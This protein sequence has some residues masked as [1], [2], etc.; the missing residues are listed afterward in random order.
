MNSR[1]LAEEAQFYSKIGS[2]FL[3]EK[4]T[5]RVL[6][7]NLRTELALLSLGYYI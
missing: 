1:F 2:R 7:T 3:A 4:V 6:L 5:F